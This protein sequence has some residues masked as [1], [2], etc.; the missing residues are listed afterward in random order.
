MNSNKTFLKISNMLCDTYKLSEYNIYL[1]EEKGLVYN[2][3]SGNIAA[4]DNKIID[5]TILNDCIENG[6]VIK[7][8]ENELNTLKKEYDCREELSDTFHLIIAVTLDCQFRCFYC[9]EEHPKIYMKDDVKK[10]LVDLIN[11]K[12]T[13]GKNIS[14]VWYG[15]EPLLDYET[16]SSLTNDFIKICDINNVEYTASMI[17]NGYLFD[18]YII[19]KIDDMCIKS[20]QIT[21]DGMKDM[22]E[23]RRPQIDG[24]PSFDK[25]VEN[26]IKLDKKTHTCVKLRINADKTNIN[27]AYKLID[28][29]KN[30]DLCDIDVTLGMMKAF[31]C[32]HSCAACTENLFSMKE[33]SEEFL[34]FRN[35]L[36]ISGFEKAVEKMFPEYKVNTCTMDAPD[37]YVVDP[38]GYMYKCI[39][40]VG[41][42]DK[43]IGNIKE[44]FDESA[45]NTYNPFLSKVC[46]E[47]I[48]FP[49]CKGGCLRNNSNGSRECNIW[50]FITEKLV[51]T[52]LDE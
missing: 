14:I 3:V 16:V 30:K 47:C 6:F 5:N 4:F 10:S 34:K 26:I 36:K 17:T 24:K 15:G 18:D 21:L 29:C 1:D 41:N 37:A 44:S 45:H 35:Y 22:H 39:S 19:S 48:Y 11:K 40:L 8:E 49:V 50:R 27:D 25:I 23:K 33:F 32:D 12:A 52:L 7:K 31:G 46:C 28:Y 9:Y 43:S 2:T 51:N 13:E 20:I 42:T 38:E